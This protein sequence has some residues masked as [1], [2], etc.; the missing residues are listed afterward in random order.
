MTKLKIIVLFILFLGLHNKGIPQ[1]KRDFARL[2]E[3][4]RQIPD[5]LTYSTINIANYINSNFLHRLKK[6]GRF[7]TG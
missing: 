2:D 1:S 6:S 3:I 4:I 5:S 7:F